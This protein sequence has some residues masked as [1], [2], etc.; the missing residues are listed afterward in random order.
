[1]K[2]DWSD[3]FVYHWKYYKSP[4]RPSISD[5]RFIK[6]NI[7]SKGKNAKVLIL[8][9]TPE[10]RNMCGQLKL[11]VT[12]IDFSKK[13]YQYLNREVKNKPKEKFVQG[14]WL[15]TVLDEKFDIILADNIVNMF[16]KKDINKLFSNV[17]KMLK[18]DGYFITRTYFRDKGEKY[19]G[20][21]SIKEYRREYPKS[22]VCSGTI[23][24][25]ILAS[26]DFRKDYTMLKDAWKVILNL[27]NK[28]LISNKELKDYENLSLNRDFL[29]F[30]PLRSD[31]EKKF[32]KFFKTKEIFYGNE[33]HLKNKLPLYVLIKK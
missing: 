18:D 3:E 17:S 7:K 29:F 27:Y 15:K 21:N 13:N 30:M 20:D 4:A 19:T 5:L 9:S 31:L 12:L 14:N 28:K 32:F 16:K 23:R 24:N 33:K 6:K 26:Y 25:L 10:Y 22:G 2:K 8:G 11:S 1:M